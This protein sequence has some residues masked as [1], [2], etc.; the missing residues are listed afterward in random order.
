MGSGPYG[1]WLVL[2]TA[3][4]LSQ[5]SDLGVGAAIVFFSAQ[6]RAGNAKGA[7]ARFLSAGLLWNSSACLLLIPLYF[8]LALLYVTSDEVA[9]ALPES[10]GFWLAVLATCALLSILLRPFMSTLVGAGLMPVDQRNQLIGTLV[11]VLGTLAVCLLAPSAVALAMVEVAWVVLP[12]VLALFSSARRGLVRIRWD[13]QARTTLTMMLRY[14][15]RS[16][17]A[18]LM[19]AITLQSGVIIAGLLLGPSAASYYSA[20][21]RVYTAARQVLSWLIE[22]FRSALSRLYPSNPQVAQRTLLAL[23]FLVT[24]AASIISVTGLLAAPWLIPAWLGDSAPVTTVSWTLT[25][26][27]AGLAVNSLYIPLAMAADSRGIPGLYLVSNAVWMVSAICLSVVLAGQ[28]GIVGIA[29]GLSTPL[30]IVV[31]LN[32]VIARRRLGLSLRSWVEVCARPVLVLVLPP[33]VLV[34]MLSAVLNRSF[35]GENLPVIVAGVYVLLQ[36]LTAIILRRHLPFDQVRDLARA[37]L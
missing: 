23:C 26:F 7:P 27:L 2:F 32:I 31:P 33:A 11:R 19:G 9:Q 6:S 13:S 16:F 10:D 25:A 17:G 28:L 24:A 3:V 30:I 20:A 14:S 36:A 18:S 15:V 34:A 35:G 5:Y 29:V 12:G 8:V 22:P 4:A 21:F 37:R 1:V